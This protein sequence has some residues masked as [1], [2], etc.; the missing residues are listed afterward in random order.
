MPFTQKQ[1]EELAARA[2]IR[3]YKIMSVTRPGNVPVVQKPSKAK[4]WMGSNLQYWA[5]ANAVT[6]EEEYRFDDK[7]R[8][9][10][11]WAIPSMKIA[12]EYEGLMSK[13]SR[14]TTAKGFTADTEK[15]N[16]AQ[17]HG[18]RVLRFT[19]M[20]YKTMVEVLNHLL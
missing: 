11:D 2:K 8:W 20:N 14:H 16:A 6:L 1:I 15:Y 4:D 3:G 9:R 7:R 18:W 13:K 19:A 5:N 17:G 10:F 12:V